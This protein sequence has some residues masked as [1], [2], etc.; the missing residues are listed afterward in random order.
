MMR[1]R[2]A[3]VVLALSRASTLSAQSAAPT[4]GSL[5]VQADLMA[6]DVAAELRAPPGAH[7][8]DVPLADSVMSWY[9]V[10]SQLIVV[11]HA[12]GSVTRRTRSAVGDSSAAAAQS[13]SGGTWYQAT[14]PP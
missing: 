14:P 2:H 5:A 7:G 10:P 6:D 4:D 1:L 13:R 3:I 9:A 12:D 11:A 8:A